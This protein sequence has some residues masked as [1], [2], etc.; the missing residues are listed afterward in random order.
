M[1]ESAYDPRDLFDVEGR[2]AIVT[3]ASSG[4]GRQFAVVLHAAGVHVVAVARREERL[5][6]LADECP[7][8]V[9]QRLDVTDEAGCIAMVDEVME[10]FGR[11]DLLVN[12]AGMGSPAP[13]VD[14]DLDAFRY[15]L[16]VDL[17]SCFNLARLVA[18]PMIAAGRGSIVNIASVYGIGSSYPL[19]N[20]SYT[21]AKGAVIN[22]TRELGGQW[23][24][25]GVRV[26]AIAPGFFRSETAE[27]F[28]TNE[29]AHARLV[30][31]TPMRRLGEERELD[32]ALIYLASDAASYVNG[33][34][35]VVDGGYTTH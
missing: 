4:L 21:A 15:T 30:Q 5:V 29:K 35:L 20:A 25:H 26:N 32:G 9:A 28:F 3:G 17:V 34:T 10:R 16:E 13:A 8:L 24:K 27:E 33:H 7:G 12:N 19:P 11:I 1:A 23:G 31:A 6:E 14:E 2:V 18:R 22:L